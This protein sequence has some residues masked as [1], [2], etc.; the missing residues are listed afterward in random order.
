M[1]GLQLCR[2]L[3][4]DWRD[5]LDAVACDHGRP[6]SHHVA[7]LAARVAALSA[8]YNDPARARADVRGSGA[9]RLGFA[10]ARDVPKGAAA[11]RELLATE[12][13]VVERTVRV[14][15]WGSGFGA[16]TWGLL[17]ALEANG[18]RCTVDATWVDHDRDA[19]EVAAAIARHRDGR[20][21]VTL[22]FK[23][24]LRNRGAVDN[25]GRFDVVLVGQV[26]SELDVGMALAVRAERH[27]DFS[28][29]CSGATPKRAVRSSS[30]NRRC[31]IARDT[32]TVSATR[33]PREGRPSSPPACTRRHAPRSPAKATGATRTSPSIYR[34]GSFRLR[35]RPAFA[36]RV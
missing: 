10:F 15:D 18:A 6:T 8:A 20:G 36:I 1:L 27:A 22:R 29:T 24:L 13:L 35:A 31:A 19:L 33:W 34:R 30:S 7:K 3:E 12:A 14:L 4:D 16:T 17:R 23:T 11:V 9:A 26:L 28:P 2:P 32:C 25:L 5:T 21:N